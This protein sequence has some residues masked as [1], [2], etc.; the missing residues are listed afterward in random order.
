MFGLIVMFIDRKSRRLGDL[1]AG[2]IV[3][4][5]QRGVKLDTLEADTRVLATTNEGVSAGNGPAIRD[6]R[7][8]TPEDRRLLR[9]YLQ[10]RATLPAEATA[11]IA[12]SLARAFAMKAGYDLGDEPPDAFLLRLARRL[13]EE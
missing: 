7:Y 10:R 11:R 5:E 13:D 1:A 9:E 8:L 12:Q 2:T 4:K 6:V 3:V